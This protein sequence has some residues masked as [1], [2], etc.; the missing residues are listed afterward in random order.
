[1]PVLPFRAAG[2]AG[3]GEIGRVWILAPACEPWRIEGGSQMRIGRCWRADQVASDTAL[4]RIASE[5]R[6]NGRNCSLGTATQSGPGDRLASFVR[7]LAEVAGA[8]AEG[9]GESRQPSTPMEVPEPPPS[10][11]AA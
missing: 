8:V 5:A 7:Y 3:D 10:P 11:A 4:T 6:G 1:M 2:I 9:A